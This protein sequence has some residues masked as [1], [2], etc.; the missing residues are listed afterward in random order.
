MGV[1]NGR[2][3]LVSG[4]WGAASIRASRRDSMGSESG[5]GEG[6]SGWVRGRGG[7]GPFFVAPMWGGGG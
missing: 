1:V 7:A 3:L 5:S 4:S 2:I 6:T